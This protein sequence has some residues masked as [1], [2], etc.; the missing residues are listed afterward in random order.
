MSIEIE[1]DTTVEPVDALLEMRWTDN[2]RKIRSDHKDR[3]GASLE[4]W[5]QVV[6]LVANRRTNRLLGGHQRLEV[7]REKGAESARVSWVDIP[8]DDEAALALALN[9]DEAQGEWDEDKL[10]AILTDI[11]N[12]GA[13]R[14][15]EAGFSRARVDSIVMR[16][17]ARAQ[18]T[19]TNTLGNPKFDNS[20]APVPSPDT[21][22]VDARANPDATVPDGYQPR[23][24]RFA[25]FTMSMPEAG[26]DRLQKAILHVQQARGLD[27]KA[28]ALIAIADAVLK[29][30][31]DD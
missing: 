6:P 2:P 11:R 19:A 30:T 4:A 28:D 20:S 24:E 1:F 7:L 12:K 23:R 14:V 8:E 18:A 16:A 27:T 31:D 3:L 5:G 25:V 9:N 26:R 13:Q 22:G 17:R 29:G 21:G 15:K 10:A